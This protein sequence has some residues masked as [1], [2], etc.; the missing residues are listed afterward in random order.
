MRRTSQAANVPAG[1]TA[2]PLS[3]LEEL[4]RRHWRDVIRYVARTFGAGPPSPEDVA[5]QAFLRLAASGTAVA[6]RNPKAFLFRSARNV[7]IDEHR[8]HAAQRAFIDGGGADAITGFDGGDAERA[9]SAKQR[10]AV[11]AQAIQAM[12]PQ[13]RRSFLMHRLQGYTFVEI[14]RR[15][16]YSESGVKK[17]VTLALDEIERAVAA[18]ENGEGAP[19]DG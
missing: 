14:A 15:T 9:L 5:Q 2:E 1:P 4:Y 16:G 3:G 13:R 12:A 7:V 6:V 19:H 10:L 11:V 18:A 17:H 8:R